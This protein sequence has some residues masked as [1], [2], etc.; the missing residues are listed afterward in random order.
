MAQTYTPY[1]IDD[2]P[3]IVLFRSVKY[4]EENN[5]WISIEDAKSLKDKVWDGKPLF[6]VV[7][8]SDDTA[9]YDFEIIDF[10]LTDFDAYMILNNKT[11]LN[12]DIPFKVSEYTIKDKVKID[13]KFKTSDEKIKIHY[14]GD[15]IFDVNFTIGDNS[16]TIILQDAGNFQDGRYYDGEDYGTQIKW[17]ISIIPAGAIIEGASLAVWNFEHY[18]TATCGD[19]ETWRI[20]NQTWESSGASDT[21]KHVNDT[22]SRQPWN[23]TPATNKWIA[24]NVT[25]IIKADVDAFNGNSTMRFEDDTQVVG[26]ISETNWIS[27]DLLVGDYD[28]CYMKLNSE[29]DSECSCGN[30]P[31]LRINYSTTTTTTSTTTTTTLPNNCSCVKN[32]VVDV[33]PSANCLDNQTLFHNSTF[34]TSEGLDYVY[35]YESCPYTCDNVTKTCAPDPFTLNSWILGIIFAILI[36]IVLIASKI[37]RFY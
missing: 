21:D 30:T 34:R 28:L 37:R 13:Q 32:I 17:N 27:G 29:E 25:N 16:T 18:E 7:Y 3:T 8:L 33:I 19:V 6:E 24:I 23:A 36:V 12:Q 26:T 11:K 35:S 2:Y 15:S 1:S 9:N 20:N 10:N 4:V 14:T 31:E 22:Y 5:A